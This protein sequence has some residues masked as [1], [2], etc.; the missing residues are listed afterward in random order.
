[1]TAQRCRSR[2]GPA[3]LL[4]SLA[5]PLAA[6][7]APL[8]V[9]DAAGVALHDLRLSPDGVTWSGDRLGGTTLAPGA[10]AALGPL[11]C[12]TFR[13]RLALADGTPCELPPRRLCAA[14]GRWE[15]GAADVASCRPPRAGAALVNGS[16]RTLLHV[17]VAPTDD[18]RW[19]VDRLPRPLDPGSS[20]ELAD[21]DC[22]AYDVKVVT[23]AGTT[24]VLQ[25]VEL[26]G[27][28]ATRVLTD[29]DLAGPPPAP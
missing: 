28:G 12:D 6:A 22:D 2:C 19:G 24:H 20:L 4:L 13:V 14:D 17:Y 9:H 3:L 15:L 10:D 11:A 16:R 21:L 29:A 5:S 1:M 18:L 27:A 8:V 25:A 23:A 7:D 26:C